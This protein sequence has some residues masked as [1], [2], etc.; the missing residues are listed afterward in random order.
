MQ[1]IT[2][3]EGKNY[4]T[5]AHNLGL[6]M[7]KHG[8]DLDVIT[9]SYMPYL[10]GRIINS[11]LPIKHPKTIFGQH[12]LYRDGPVILIDADCIMEDSFEGFPEIP[13]NSVAGRF[14]GVDPVLNL[15]FL[16]STL[17]IFGSVD[18]AILTSKLWTEITK[19][20]KCDD[21][22]ALFKAIFSIPKINLGGSYD[23]PLPGLR[24]LGVTTADFN[25]KNLTLSI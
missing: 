14:T 25:H 9:N 4:Q 17:L 16:A 13:E 23:Y 22:T 1:I 10:N 20:E 12:I 8:L 6:S 11:T 18:L 15:Q 7:R 5:L 24:H 19:S 21:E 3:A 2:V